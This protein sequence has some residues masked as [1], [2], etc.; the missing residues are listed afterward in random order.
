MS[1]VVGILNR[2]AP[3]S[4]FQTFFK[5]FLIS[6]ECNLYTLFFLLNITIIINGVFYLAG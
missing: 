2:P 5:S 1:V 3:E 6:I 4:F